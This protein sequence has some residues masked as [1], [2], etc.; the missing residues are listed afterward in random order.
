MITIAGGKWTT[1]R[2][3]AEDV[4]DAAIASGRM[5]LSVRPCVSESLHLL[6][7]QGYSSTL[8]AQVGQARGSTTS[9]EQWWIK[10]GRTV[11]GPVVGGSMCL[12]IA[13][14]DIRAFELV[15]CRIPLESPSCA[16][17]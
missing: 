3:M 15:V 17:A 2:K 7:A 4:V 6:G 11:C 16:P 1:Y 9:F 14:P 8:Y 13:E 12:W 5:P 10:D